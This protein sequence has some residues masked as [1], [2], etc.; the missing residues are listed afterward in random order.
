MFVTL[1]ERWH[2]FQ[3][4]K[5]IDLN[6]LQLSLSLLYNV[7]NELRWFEFIFCDSECVFSYIVQVFE[8]K[9]QKE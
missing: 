9:E 8:L 6:I 1:N 5:Q 3:V 7:L 2:F 4:R